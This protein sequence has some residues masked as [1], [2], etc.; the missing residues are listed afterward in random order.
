MTK[1]SIKNICLGI[2]IGLIITSIANISA[3]PKSLSKEQIINEANKY[4]LIVMDAKALIQKQPPKPETVQQDKPKQTESSTIAIESGNSSEDIAE[5][6]ISNKLI[7]NKQTFISKLK[8]LNK[9]NKVQIGTFK[10][11]QGASLDEI[12]DTLTSSPK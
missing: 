5:K 2:G 1:Y 9:E 7:D 3:A 11:Q 12:I 8:E 6:L 10:I 4:G